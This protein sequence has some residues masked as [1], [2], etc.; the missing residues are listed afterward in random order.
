M[1]KGAFSD[2]V[3]TLNR[4]VGDIKISGF[5]SSVT[6]VSL[7]IS[8]PTSA[9]YSSDEMLTNLFTT[10]S[11]SKQTIEIIDGVKLTAYTFSDISPESSSSRKDIYAVGGYEGT[12]SLINPSSSSYVFNFNFALVYETYR[13]WTLFDNLNTL[14]NNI[15]TVTINGGAVNISL[16]GHTSMESNM[17]YYVGVYTGSF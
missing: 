1:L 10:S 8:T 2:G 15:A 11:F 3:L 17:E 7:D 9:G 13:G 5:D 12:F 4:S 6:D 14:K 16:S